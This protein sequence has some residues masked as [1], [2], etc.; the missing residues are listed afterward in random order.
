MYVCLCMY[1]IYMY[2][3]VYYIYVYKPETMHFKVCHV[4][5]CHL[6]SLVQIL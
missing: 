6:G 1:I 3:Y 4:H 2:V 5:C